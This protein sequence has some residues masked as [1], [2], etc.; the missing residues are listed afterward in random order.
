[1]VKSSIVRV[2]GSETFETHES[3]IRE[4]LLKNAE[5]PSTPDGKYDDV[6]GH[7][8]DLHELQRFNSIRNWTGG[9]TWFTDFCYIARYPTLL[10]LLLKFWYLISL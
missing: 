8:G 2:L 1:M 7:H 9:A 5:P 4:Q 6:G 3:F 10:H